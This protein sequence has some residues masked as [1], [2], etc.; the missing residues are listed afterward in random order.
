[1]GRQAHRQLGE[2]ERDRIA[3]YVL[4]G[5]RAAEAS[6]FLEH[7]E[8]CAT[9]RL[10][11][12][13][14]KPVTADLVLAGPSMAPPPGLKGRTLARA[15]QQRFALRRAALRTWHASDAPGVEIT[16]LRADA[17]SGRHTILIR[18][19]AG[20]SIP[21]HR[22]PRPEEC[23]IVEGD[24]RDGAF[25]LAA[26]DYLCHHTGSQHRISTRGGCVLLVT[27]AAAEGAMPSR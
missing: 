6:S 18:M 10:E 16:Q 27:L 9:C 22:H 1:M 23:F 21:A 19:Q 4:D 24:L 11:V 7:L 14:L 20:A 3:L 13:R 17:E 8:S 2:A 5:M 25:D 12:G 15:G 26:G